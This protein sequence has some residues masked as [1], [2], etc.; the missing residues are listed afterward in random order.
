MINIIKTVL[1]NYWGKLS[2]L[3][4]MYLAI[5]I[6]TVLWLLLP[7]KINDDFIN[8]FTGFLSVFLLLNSLGV[9]LISYFWKKIIPNLIGALLIV[10]SVLFVCGLVIS[11]VAGGPFHSEEKIESINSGIYSTN[12]YLINGGATVAFSIEVRRE[13]DF[14][15]VSISRDVYSEYRAS[16]VEL[17]VIGDSILIKCEKGRKLVNASGLIF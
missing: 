10:L 11:M 9:F 6:I 7:I 5:F 1:R 16:E 4:K 17:K 13:I 3:Q 2:I 12:A 14:G 8:Q 15:I